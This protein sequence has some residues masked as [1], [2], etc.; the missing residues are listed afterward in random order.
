MMVI[1]KVK[2]PATGDLEDYTG[3]M[4]ISDESADKQEAL[5][6]FLAFYVPSLYEVMFG[7]KEG[8]LE[9][10]VD[11]IIPLLD[12]PSLL[13]LRVPFRQLKNFK[14]ADKMRDLAMYKFKIRFN[15]L[16]DGSTWWIT[17]KE[18]R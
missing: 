15:D 11:E 17:W 3:L 9:E 16:K 7:K 14:V 18:A 10:M 8:S 1:C 5:T 4:R 12:G 6:E 2:N 13:S